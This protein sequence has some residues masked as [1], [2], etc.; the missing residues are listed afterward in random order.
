ML[1]TGT[2]QQ[3]AQLYDRYMIIIIIIIIIIILSDYIGN[4]WSHWNSNKRSE[5]KLG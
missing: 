3:V 2:G 5:E 1:E 4:N